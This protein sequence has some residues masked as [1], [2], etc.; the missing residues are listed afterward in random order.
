MARILITDDDEMDRVLLNDVLGGAGHD[1][2][3]A[4]EGQSA[5]DAYREQEIDVVLTDLER[6]RDAGALVTLEKPV[7]PKALLEAVERAMRER[8]KRADPWT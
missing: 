8:K 7:D 3:F 4:R 2:Y 5:L 6:A 1:L